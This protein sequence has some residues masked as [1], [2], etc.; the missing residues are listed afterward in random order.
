MAN[1]KTKKRVNR[2]PWVDIA[3][4]I[5]IILMIVGHEL[6]QDRLRVLIFSF[7]MPL[8]FILSG[9][10]A[11]PVHEWSRLWSTT[12]KMFWR[13][14]VLATLMIICFGLELCIF[15]HVPIKNIIVSTAISVIKGSNG[16]YSFAGVMW[17]LY[18]YFWARILFDFL[19]IVIKPRYLGWVLTIISCFAMLISHFIWLPQCLD[20]APIASFFMWAGS[21]WH[22]KE[23]DYHRSVFDVHWILLLMV[24]YWIGLVIMGCYIELSIR[25]Y[26]LNMLCALE[27]VC[28]TIIVSWLSHFTEHLKLLSSSFEFLGKQTLALLCIHD[29]DLYWVY[30]S[31]FIRS[32]WIAALLRLLEDLI[33][34]GVFYWACKFKDHYIKT[35]TA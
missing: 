13:I 12:K 24:V 6:P 10:T 9:Y 35:K 2:I 20:I 26:A 17:F 31:P 34:L 28:G 21:F 15:K 5:A 8:F 14:W 4:G 11:R 22:Q 18:V 33:L 32:F 3:K 19:Q 7:H 23:F 1:A 30:W 16:G 29:L 27:A 25:H